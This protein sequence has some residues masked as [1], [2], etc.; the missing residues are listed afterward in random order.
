MVVRSQYKY[1]ADPKGVN[2]IRSS[3]SSREKLQL[4]PRPFQTNVASQVKLIHNLAGLV[5][6]ILTVVGNNSFPGRLQYLKYELFLI[7]YRLS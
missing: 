6:H 1:M 4:C 5:R 2:N 3:C 7:T